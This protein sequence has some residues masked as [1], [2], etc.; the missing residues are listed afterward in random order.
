[1]ISDDRITDASHSPLFAA[2]SVVEAADS[3]NRT[4][5]LTPSCR[6]MLQ[7]LLVAVGLC[8]VGRLA[9][10]AEGSMQ[11]VFNYDAML[12]QVPEWASS[13][14]NAD[15][16][17]HIVLDSQADDAA[18]NAALEDFPSPED[19]CWFDC[20]T[21]SRAVE[22]K[23]AVWDIR[24]IP[25]SICRILFELNSGPFVE[26]LE[27]LTGIA[28]L[29][30]DPHFYGAGV[31]QILS[32]GRLE[33]HADHNLNLK[34][35]LYRRVSVALYLNKD[36]QDSYGGTLELWSADM[37][38]PVQRIVPLFNRMV[39]FSNSETSFHGHPDPI[40]GP[41]GVTRKSLAAWYLS[42]EPHPSHLSV[43]H[44]AIFP[45]VADDAGAY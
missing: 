19:G 8:G 23:Q 17:G 30:P 28:H 27:A 16:F 44:K 29:V 12:R 34:L 26:F 36:W 39:V 7:H 35:N 43:P 2:S 33:I 38:G 6:D 10:V 40:A 22:R 24:K 21:D 15:P 45:R 20:T 32:S 1:M 3:M 18:L 13:Y 31:H 42:P 11:T 37:K 4:F 25:P 14:A 5:V 9:P 41:P